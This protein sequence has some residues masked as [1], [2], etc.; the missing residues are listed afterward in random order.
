MW[1]A[2]A[3]VRMPSARRSHAA[4][5]PGLNARPAQPTRRAPTLPWT[6]FKPVPPPRH[7][8]TTPIRLTTTLTHLIDHLHY[9][10][11]HALP[12]PLVS[13][14]R[15]LGVMVDDVQRQRFQQ[16]ALGTLQAG[17]LPCT[18]GP[19]Q[20]RHGRTR[21]PRPQQRLWIQPTQTSPLADQRT[22]GMAMAP[23]KSTG[24]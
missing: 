16:K 24:K 10:G 14:W 17:R 19:F 21:R 8:Q 22:L 20:Q 7:P 18:S 23:E 2:L 1:M 5:R 11:K 4:E 12:P 9:F 6:L 3:C 13:D 15:W